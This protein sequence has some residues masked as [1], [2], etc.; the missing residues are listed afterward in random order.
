MQKSYWQ[1][2]SFESRFKQRK[3]SRISEIG[4]QRVPDI[5]SFVRTAADWNHLDNTYRPQRLCSEFQG[6]V[7]HRPHNARRPPTCSPYSAATKPD[8]CM[9]Q[10]RIQ[11][12][13]QDCSTSNPLDSYT[14]TINSPERTKSVI[15]QVQTFLLDTCAYRSVS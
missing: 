12:Q 7:Q 15:L 4:W 13:G 5:M 8:Y 10:C 6:P 1:K 11:G 14:R 2:V 9:K 3:G